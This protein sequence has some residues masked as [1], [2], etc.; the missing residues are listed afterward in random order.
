MR[1]RR[2]DARIPP[3]PVNPPDGCEEHIARLDLAFPAMLMAHD[4]LR[5][6][7]PNDTERRFCLQM[8]EYALSGERPREWP[9]GADH[10][11]HHTREP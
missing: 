6:G 11:D 1:W 5:R 3:K 2:P 4:L 10:A 7:H 9:R 8:L